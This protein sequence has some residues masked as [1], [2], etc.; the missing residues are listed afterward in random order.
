MDRCFYCNNILLGQYYHD[1]LGNKGCASHSDMLTCASCGRFLKPGVAYSQ[2]EPERSICKICIANEVTESNFAWIKE[3]VIRRLCKVGFQDIQC[4]WVNFRIISQKQM[5]EECPNAVGY[6]TGINILNQIV[7]VLSHTN[8][9]DF[10]AV[11]AHELLHSWQM[12]NNLTEYKEYSQNETSKK[13]CEGFAQ[14]GKYLIYDTIDHPYAKYRKEQMFFSNDEVYG[15]PF[16][17]LFERFKQIGWYGIIRE[18][19]QS[20]LKI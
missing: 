15:V 8:K 13:I 17:R 6:Q 11:L 19:R 5:E 3:Q 9:I 2:I 16:K 10:A 1:W 4:D 14:L 7:S 12:Q 18:A 20:K